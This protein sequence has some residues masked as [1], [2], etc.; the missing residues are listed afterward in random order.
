MK[1]E[2]AAGVWNGMRKDYQV[3]YEFE[4]VILDKI[5]M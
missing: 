4:N 3:F 1:Y 5:T 2:V